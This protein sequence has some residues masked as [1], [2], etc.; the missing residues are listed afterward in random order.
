MAKVAAVHCADKIKLDI[1]GHIVCT[2]RETLLKKRSFFK[3]MLSGESRGRA[4]DAERTQRRSTHHGP[5]PLVLVDDDQ[6]VDAAL[7]AVVEGR[8]QLRVRRDLV[9]APV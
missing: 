7:L 5:V 1:G 3:T 8:P 9:D 6:Q 2:R 4:V